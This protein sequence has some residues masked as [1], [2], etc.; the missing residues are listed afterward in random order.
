M[1]MWRNSAVNPA[2]DSDCLLV[3]DGS[4]EALRRCAAGDISPEDALMALISHARSEREIEAAL[5]DAIWN[6]LET[7]N[8]IRAERLA[9]V[10][11]L[12]NRFRKPVHRPVHSL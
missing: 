6:A 5:G 11:K 7:R 8:S 2:T 3:P 10:Q 9:R 4:S 12:W 1:L